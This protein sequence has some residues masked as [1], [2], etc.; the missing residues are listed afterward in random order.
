MDV[1]SLKTK[2]SPEEWQLR[3]D[4]A[5]CYRLVAHYGWSDLV[6]THISARI[7][8]PEHHFL[9]NPYGLM[10]DE[11]TAS[12]LVKVDAECNK[13][14]D[15]PFPVNPA[16][17]VIHSAV[18]EA[19]EDAGCVL[20]THTRAGVAV[21]AQAA[22]VL[23]ISQQST[24]VLAGLA[25]HAYEGVAFRDD[26][27]PRLQADLGSANFLM[28]RNHG[29]LTV[30][31]S[32]GDAFLSMYVFESTCQIQLS[33]QAGGP[34]TEVD[35]QIVA[36]VAE[37]MRVQTSGLGGAFVWPA[38]LRKLDRLGADYAR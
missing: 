34:L 18:H 7:P 5:A 33:A 2:V 38:L 36:G 30:G 26:E 8:G 13:V 19:R 24:F 6:F 21:S 28:L 32:I 20:H 25:Y 3:C 17:F 16:G 29:L 4:L 35:P 9:I 23:P 1:P 12:S 22:G 37:S 31:P 11:I 10:F 14:I 27:K 15:S